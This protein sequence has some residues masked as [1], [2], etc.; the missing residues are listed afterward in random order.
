MHLDHDT[1]QDQEEVGQS[2]LKV[3][4][5]SRNTKLLIIICTT[6]IRNT[7]ADLMEGWGLEVKKLFFINCF[8]TSTRLRKYCHL[9]RGVW[10]LQNFQ[11]CDF[12]IFDFLEI[13]KFIFSHNWLKNMHRRLIV[14]S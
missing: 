6:C 3:P 10:Y 14:A 2:V 9:Q 12:C 11:N 1:K 4:K 5:V 13:I 7:T 8:T